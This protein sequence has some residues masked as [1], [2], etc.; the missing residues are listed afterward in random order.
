MKIIMM[1]KVRLSSLS[2]KTVLLPAFLLL[3]LSISAQDLSKEIVKEVKVA[4]ESTI[5]I[6]LHGE[7]GFKINTWDK[8]VVKHVVK[9]SVVPEKQEEAQDFLNNL[10][11]EV[12]ESKNGKLEIG[13]GMFSNNCLN[14]KKTSSNGKKYT[15]TLS[16]G[17]KYKVK[18]MKIT[19]EIYIPKT[20]NV[21]IDA[22]HSSVVVGDL[23][24][25]LSADS[26]S[27]DLKGGQVKYLNLKGKNGKAAFDKIGTATLDCT[28]TEFKTNDAGDMNISS[29]MTKFNIGKVDKLMI[30]ETANDEFTINSADQLISLKS[31]FTNYDI[32]EL[33]STMDMRSV[34]GDVTIE[35]VKS[36][37]EYID[38]HNGTSTVNLG[39]GATKN[40]MINAYDNLF[41]EYKYPEKVKLLKKDGKVK[42]VYLMGEENK[43]GKIN[44]KCE[45]CKINF[46][47]K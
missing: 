22:F 30:S 34:S 10:E 17:K 3:T 24:S 20:M 40:Y 11:V 43:A 38:I 15:Y 31:T 45:S 9:V 8:D 44:I 18:S 41:T 47:D 6:T 7:K 19:G 23:D 12:Q 42:E 5:S 46:K 4:N 16:N 2:F 1:L 29:S 32:D 13:Y 25:Q 35:E 39:V 36:G 21:E 27:S 37:F 33:S 26:R 28:G 14:I